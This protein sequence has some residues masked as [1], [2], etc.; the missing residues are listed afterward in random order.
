MVHVRID[1]NCVTC[2]PYSADPGY[3]LPYHAFPPS[4]FPELVESFPRT[5]PTSTFFRVN[6]ANA[7]LLTP[8]PYHMHLQLLL[9][10]Q[11][12]IVSFNTQNG[13]AFH[14]QVIVVSFDLLLRCSFVSSQLGIVV[15]IGGEVF[16]DDRVIHED[17]LVPA[18]LLGIIGRWYGAN[19]CGDGCAD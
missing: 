13:V 11:H 1:R 18:W 16:E 8:I 2:G 17:L 7:H 6:T 12:L 14:L 5:S 10:G 4:T 19:M 3:L 15:E 9:D